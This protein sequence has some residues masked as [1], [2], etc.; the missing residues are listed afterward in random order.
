MSLVL[1][2][3]FLLFLVFCVLLLASLEL[4]LSLS[5]TFAILFGGLH[6]PRSCGWCCSVDWPLGRLG[7]ELVWR[8][9]EIRTA[10]SLMRF[11]LLLLVLCVLLF[12]SLG[13]GS[14]F[15]MVDPLWV[16]LLSLLVLLCGAVFPPL[17]GGAAFNPLAG[18][19]ALSGVGVV[20]PS[21]RSC[22]VLLPSPSP[23]WVLLFCPSPSVG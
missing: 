12:G 2:L 19:A 7:N 20:L 18:G 11:F 5:Q 3:L 14:T 22:G 1:G 8:V 15:A 17:V 13:R 4:A 16:M 23:L 21:P 10:N 9:K 6:L